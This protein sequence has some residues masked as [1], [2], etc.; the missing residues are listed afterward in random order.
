MTQ[1]SSSKESESVTQTWP[2]TGKWMS[3]ENV[4][5]TVQKKRTYI[6]AALISFLVLM[7][8]V[9][10][11]VMIRESGSV[12]DDE[13]DSLTP[14]RPELIPFTARNK[15]T[16]EQSI[17]EA[18]T[19]TT[20][21][22]STAATTF[23][24]TTT[25]TTTVTTTTAVTTTTT[26]TP[27]TTSTTKAK[28][29]RIRLSPWT[30]LCTVG[31]AMNSSTVHP[32]DG[33]CDLFFFDSAYRGGVNKLSDQGSIRENFNIFL[34]L[35]KLYR[36]TELGMGFSSEFIDE[37][38][39]DLTR[40]DVVLLKYFWRRGVFHF[41]IIDIPVRDTDPNVL[42]RAFKVLKALGKLAEPHRR[43]GKSSYVVMGTVLLDVALINEKMRNFYQPDL[44]IGHGHYTYLDQSRHICRIMP[45]T[46]IVRNFSENW[47]YPYDLGT[48]VRD[49]HEIE[50]LGA[51]TLWMI[52]VT[53]KGR[54]AT[55]VVPGTQPRIGDL[56][57]HNDPSGRFSS[58]RELCN[59]DYF[60]SL[61]QYDD[62]YDAMYMVTGDRVFS[63]DNEVSFG[64]K[65]CSVKAQHAELRFGIA[66][67]DL[68][69]DDYYGDCVQQNVFP[70][71][72]SRLR[73]LRAIVDHFKTFT[74]SG[75]LDLF[76]K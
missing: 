21:P 43:L 59:D 40:T 28:S 24:T 4:N 70:K 16:E 56:C 57:V 50:K 9:M 29:T 37:V 72:H 20:P 55:A 36:K 61:L 67:Y 26:T 6:K 30:L 15:S 1:P 52:S 58:Y 33:L 60:S 44:F 34:S 66:A 65:L 47:G 71:P 76:P 73:A 39:E 18:V 75:C 49:M 7:V 69:Y 13:D 48:A 68:E 38:E 27:A 63:Y 25:T 14:S 41:G 42:P 8:L 12:D 64:R 5:D 17:T 31:V 19:T 51:T 53:M 62:K 45:P 22:E 3:G 11:I 2:S 54:W 23:P 32:A 35:V 74:Q 46:T 10:V